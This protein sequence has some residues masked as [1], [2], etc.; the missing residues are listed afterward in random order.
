MERLADSG[1]LQ[2]EAMMDELMMKQG[3]PLQQYVDALESKLMKWFRVLPCEEDKSLLLVPTVK[4]RVL[5]AANLINCAELMPNFVL[6]LLKFVSLFD[7]DQVRVSIYESGSTDLTPS[8]LDL[9]QRI[10]IASNIT[11]TIII[12]GEL[13]RDL[14]EDRIEFLAKIR[15][16]AIAPML[17]WNRGPRPW[18]AQKVVFTNDVYFCPQHILRLLLHRDEDVVCGMDFS[19]WISSFPR[20]VQKPLMVRD[21]TQ[22]FYLPSSFVRFLSNVKR[23]LRIWRQSLSRVDFLRLE[24][25]LVFYD[26]WPTIDLDGVNLIHTPPYILES[27]SKERLNLGYTAYV[28]SC[29]NGMAILNAKP[30]YQSK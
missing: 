24:I 11:S 30:L 22:R 4:E 7:E 12:K 2:V 19:L 1:F 9:L 15:N 3:V 17:E 18:T 23:F 20:S 16:E 5:V 10:L 25:P 21:L 8:W 13:I 28:H 6:Q 14:K 27:E 26:R 29:W